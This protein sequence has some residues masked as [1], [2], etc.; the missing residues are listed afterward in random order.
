M[1]NNKP[2]TKFT[3]QDNLTLFHHLNEKAI[4]GNQQAKQLSKKLQPRYTTKKMKLQYD[5]YL[6]RQ[7]HTKACKG[8]IT[9]YQKLEKIK[10]LWFE[11]EEWERIVSLYSVK[12]AK[13]LLKKR[14]IPQKPNHP[15]IPTCQRLPYNYY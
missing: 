3:W 11:W 7:L 1:P 2:L 4:C 10:K 5:E 8:N 6:V 15:W 13:S 14:K 9:A 12:L